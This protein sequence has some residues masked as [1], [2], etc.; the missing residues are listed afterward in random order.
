MGNILD[1]LEN[2]IS[3]EKT[4]NNCFAMLQEETER[5]KFLRQCIEVIAKIAELAP[6]QTCTLVVCILSLG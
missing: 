5:Q 3:G 2:Q 6:T 1:M 4:T